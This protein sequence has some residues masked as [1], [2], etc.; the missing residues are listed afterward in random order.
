MKNGGQENMAALDSFWK[1]EV[2]R[3]LTNNA[4]KNTAL[5][6]WKTKSRHTELE[7]GPLYRVK[8]SLGYALTSEQWEANTAIIWLS[9][10][11]SPFPDI[12]NIKIVSLK[13]RRTVW[14]RNRPLELI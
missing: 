5:D 2:K 10:L 4:F 8:L 11:P 6:I 9:T 14:R 1:K 12:E 13:I 3:S 7:Y